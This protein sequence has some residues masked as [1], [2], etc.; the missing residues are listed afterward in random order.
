MAYNNLLKKLTTPVTFILIGLVARILPHP[1]NFAPIGAMALFGGVYMSKKQA[2]IL[3]IAAMI[4]SDFIIGFDSLP[5]RLTIYASFLIMVLIGFWLKKHNKF[6]NI[7]IASL[8]GSLLFFLA[9]NFAVWAFG[10]LYPKTIGGLTECYLLA[11]PFFRNTILGDFFYSGVFFGGY[12]F[13]G[14][15]AGKNNRV[16]NTS[17][18]TG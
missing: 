4:L 18:R 8:A 6:G 1:A 17:P 9:T 10:A 12:N 14:N 2:L 3:P 16:W 15:L 5:M 7:V 13:I 11:I